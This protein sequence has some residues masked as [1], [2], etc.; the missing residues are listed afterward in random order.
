MAN[1]TLTGTITPE[2]VKPLLEWVCELGV[3]TLETLYLSTVGGDFYSAVA[4][5]DAIQMKATSLR[6]CALGACQSAG[7]IILA[8]ARP[9][10]RYCGPTTQFMVHQPAAVFQYV[11]VDGQTVQSEEYADIWQDKDG[12]R[13]RVEIL[14]PGYVELLRLSDVVVDLARSDVGLK[15]D[16]LRKLYGGEENR[17]FFDAKEAQG[18]GFISR[19]YF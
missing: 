7:T 10:N 5:R 2:S 16:V 15:D 14:G 18:L 6:I 19:T 3:G 4:V 13:H 11:Q 8:A 12:M 1:F 9:E 17:Y